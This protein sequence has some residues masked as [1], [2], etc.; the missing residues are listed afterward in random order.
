MDIEFGSQAH[1][2]AIARTLAACKANK[3]FASIF[4]K[5][6]HG[7]PPFPILL[8]VPSESGMSGEQ[9]KKRLAQGFDFVSIATD[10]DSLIREFSRQLEAVKQ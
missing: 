2:D 8:T 10:T 5:Y 7:F 9:A 6:R 3:K 4:C 1:E